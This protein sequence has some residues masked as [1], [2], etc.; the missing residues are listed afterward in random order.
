MRARFWHIIL[1]LLSTN[2]MFA[3]SVHDKISS[4]ADLD[5]RFLEHAIKEQIDSLRQKNGINAL[6]NDLILHKAALDQAKFIKRSG[7]LSSFQDDPEKANPELRVTYFGG[8]EYHV[9]EAIGRTYLNKTRK[10]K[11]R[12]KSFINRTY[13]DL[14]YDIAFQWN[15]S[16][17]YAK[18]IYNEDWEITGCAISLVTEKKQI[19]VVQQFAWVEWKY[20]FDENKKYFKYSNYKPPPSITS[21]SE[22]DSQ[23]IAKKFDFRLRAPKRE[24]QC[25]ECRDLAV[26][27]HQDSLPI[28]LRWRGRSIRVYT[29]NIELVDALFNNRRDGLAVE[30]IEYIPYDCGNGEYYLMPSRRNQQSILNGAVQEP[31]YKRRLFKRWRMQKRAFNQKKREKAWGIMKEYRDEGDWLLKPRDVRNT[32]KEKWKPRA[33]D[34]KIGKHLRKPNAFYEINILV[35]QKKKVCHVLHYSNICGETIQEA[36]DIPYLTRFNKTP[37]HADTM[38]M[39]LKF[40]IPFKKGKAT[41]NYDDIKPLLDSV[42]LEDF[43]VKD[44]TIKAYASVE[45]DY[46]VNEALQQQRAESIISAMETVQEDAIPAVIE[47]KEDWDYF[48][49][50]IEEDS[51]HLDWLDKEEEEIKALL[52]K[53]KYA[54]EMEPYLAKQRRAEVNFKILYQYDDQS[55]GRFLV[56]LFQMHIDSAFS[57]RMIRLDHRD[58]AEAL[59]YKMW[60]GVTNGTV[61]TASLLM[62]HIPTKRL[63]AKLINNQLWLERKYMLKEGKTKEW[64]EATRDKLAHLGKLRKIDNEL[65]FN[66]LNFCI[67]EWKG[68]SLADASMPPKKIKKKLDYL[69]E[70]GF[71]GEKMYY[72]E[73]NYHFKAANYYIKKKGRRN[74]TLRDESVEEIKQYFYGLDINDSIALSFA[75]FFVHYGQKRTAEALLAPFALEDKPNPEILA[76]YLKVRYRHP[77]EFPNAGYV[78]ELLDSYSILSKAQWCQLF[79]GPCNIS[80]QI[81]DDERIRNLYCKEC[82]DKKNFAQDAD[83]KYFYN[84]KVVK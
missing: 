36:K 47:A 78:D 33:L 46:L 27:A 54:R 72:L 68:T 6:A 73:V 20:N 82:S 23:L 24:K 66:Y 62:L 81:F 38:Q 37:Y 19:K 11:G 17:K 18:I 50:Q 5:I 21:F 15:R 22:V 83:A 12:K 42:A 8:Q 76:Y 9:Q 45:G 71:G 25:E 32:L 79:V 29:E 49:E 58:Y 61:D 52:T 16:R 55:Y 84:M 77:E 28:A 30:I 65:L 34:T 51:I 69:R 75:N 35:I 39:D 44:A 7:S 59:Q 43:I 26:L 1:F 13:Y 4:M 74:R 70:N 48:Y 80:F 31:Y 60:Q 56:K 3:Q 2:L 67:R 10:Q 14:A 40:S 63:F 41:Y 53:P 64:R 57:N